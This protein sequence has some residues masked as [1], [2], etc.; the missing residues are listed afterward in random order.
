M[1]VQARDEDGAA[2]STEE[3]REDLVGLIAAGH[4]T[5][6]A[7]IAWGAALLAHNPDVRERA[8]PRP[9]RT[10]T[11]TSARWSRRCCGSAPRSRSRR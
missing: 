3:L 1:L 8:A 9:A 4:E 5:T 11:P 2:L 10:T 7:A 6:A